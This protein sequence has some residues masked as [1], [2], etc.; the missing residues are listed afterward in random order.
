LVG[1]YKKSYSSD[2]PIQST[3]LDFGEADTSVNFVLGEVGVEE[4][5]TKSEPFGLCLNSSN[6]FYRQITISYQL[7]DKSKVSIKVYDATGKLVKT[8]V[9][10]EK[11][12]GS[13]TVDWDAKGLSSGIYFT[14]LVTGNY[15]ATEKLILIK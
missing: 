3:Y 10:E 5:M 7:P 1:V 8:L 4:C 2:P 13:H 12:P 14:K 11:Y 6:P 9:D 15:K